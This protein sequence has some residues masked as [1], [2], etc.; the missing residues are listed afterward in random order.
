MLIYAMLTGHIPVGNDQA[1]STSEARASFED[2]D[3]LLEAA[4]AKDIPEE[5]KEILKQ[6]LQREQRKRSHLGNLLDWTLKQMAEPD[7][8]Q[9]TTNYSLWMKTCHEEYFEAMYAA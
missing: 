3:T 2:V 9:M 5:W 7:Q 6:C 4:P 8:A 1:N